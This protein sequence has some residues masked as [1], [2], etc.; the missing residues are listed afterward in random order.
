MCLAKRSLDLGW[1]DITRRQ[2]M[3]NGNGKSTSP[4]LVNGLQYRFVFDRRGYDVGFAAVALPCGARPKIARL[5]LSVAPLVK[6]TSSRFSTQSS[7]ATC[8]GSC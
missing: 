6:S 2:R 5:L 8:S 3:D 7:D 4:Q 1:V